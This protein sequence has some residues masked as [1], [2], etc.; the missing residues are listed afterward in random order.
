MKPPSVSEARAAAADARDPHLRLPRE[1][2]V[3]RVAEAVFIVVTAY[4]A[5]SLPLT[6]VPGGA[7]IRARLVFEAC[8]AL[9]VLL[10]LPRRPG[11]VRFLAMALAFYVLVG[12]LPHLA[13]L[14]VR[15]GLA[16]SF[17]LGLLSLVITVAACASQGVVLV[18]CALVRPESLAGGD[19]R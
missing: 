4:V 13:S 3:A 18:A 16:P 17:M 12:C 11:P 14:P 8:V 2:R 19:P 7:M 1:L 5:L 10:A 6:A 15:F 9:A